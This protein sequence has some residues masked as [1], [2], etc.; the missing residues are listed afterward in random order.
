[1]KDYDSTLPLTDNAIM[2]YNLTSN[3]WEPTLLEIDT[4]DS[5][6]MFQT[7]IN[8]PIS[9]TNIG[10]FNC[11]NMLVSSGTDN[12]SVVLNG[13][14]FTIL[15]QSQ[16]QINFTGFYHLHLIAQANQANTNT[17]II[18]NGTVVAAGS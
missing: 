11:L 10:G 17:L 18:R 12:L 8:T 14:K 2:K 7:V 15:N 9:T 3:K 1:M 5:I 13:D 4:I 6:R 16:L